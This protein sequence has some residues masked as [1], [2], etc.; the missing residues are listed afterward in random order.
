MWRSRGHRLAL[1]ILVSLFV[2]RTRGCTSASQTNN[3]PVYTTGP[4]YPTGTC[5][6]TYGC[7]VSCPYGCMAC[8]VCMLRC[9]A[10]AP[11]AGAQ[12][13]LRARTRALLTL[14]AS[15]GLSAFA[16]KPVSRASRSQSGG[17]VGLFDPSCAPFGANPAGTVI[18]IYRSELCPFY[19]T[20]RT[21][22]VWLC[23]FLTPPPSVQHHRA[24][25][26]TVLLPL[27]RRGPGPS[28]AC[29]RR[30]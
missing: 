9:A 17:V 14:C 15:C 3:L 27:P 21:G 11:C 1:C 26:D 29:A 13:A 5:S 8:T 28:L 20:R 18:T 6:T 4:Y 10:A 12:L 24:A 23:G 25:G 19:V 2:A 30:G 7:Q 16:F 22:D